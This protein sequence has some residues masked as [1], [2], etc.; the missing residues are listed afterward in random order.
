[1]AAH[2]KSMKKKKIT[3]Q[4]HS[5]R[6]VAIIALI[7]ITFIGLLSYG[8]KNSFVTMP[9]INQVSNASGLI[10][11]HL[12]PAQVS[13]NLNDTT[14][15]KL[16]IDAGNYKANG[17]VADISYDS[18]D[19]EIISVT[20][21]PFFTEAL[22]EATW[23]NG[24]I[25]FTYNLPPSH[26][27]KTGEGEVATIVAKYKQ[28]SPS[29]SFGTGTMATIKD[30]NNSGNVLK[31]A[32][33]TQFSLVVTAA[34]PS[35]SVV[36]SPTS[37]PLAS[38]TQSPIASPVAS[39]TLSPSVTPTASPTSQNPSRTTK[40]VLSNDPTCNRLVLKWDKIDGA[41]GYY[42]DISKNAQFSAITT[43]GKLRPEI[44]E[45]MFGNLQADTI[46]YARI[47][48]SEI[49]DFPRFGQVMQFKTAASCQTPPPSSPRQTVAPSRTPTP[50][51]SVVPSRTPT[52][53]IKPS[54]LSSFIPT[55]TPAIPSQIPYDDSVG[56]LS[57][58]NQFMEVDKGVV[59]ETPGEP[60][61]LTKLFISIGNFF[62]GIVGLFSK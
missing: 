20:Q 25:S 36:A 44:S 15:I 16:M 8:K 52:P 39:P 19:L 58:L 33:D 17:V 18:S 56:D 31:T 6:T 59:T 14:T 50:L 53:S 54:P 23:T 57:D 29:L 60:S 49:H 27:G 28:G 24:K 40:A 22:E 10:D 55:Q 4:S 30:S 11:L 48:Q 37:S 32:T 35:P 62:E 51:R 3:K 2:I 21:G 13:L 7:T 26:E 47:T 61:F 45:F 43:S 46:Y 1:M 42:V 12:T 41:K 34:S 5:N 38:P 9:S